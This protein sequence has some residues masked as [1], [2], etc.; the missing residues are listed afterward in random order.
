MTWMLLA[1]SA[2]TRDLPDG[3]EDAEVANGVVQSQCTGAS[4][5]E[6]RIAAMWVGDPPEV[7]LLVSSTPFRCEQRVA[8]LY[9][10]GADGLDVLLQPEFMALATD[11]GCFCTYDVEV[12]VVTP[13]DPYEQVTV[14]RRGDPLAGPYEPIVVGTVRLDGEPASRD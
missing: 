8:A 13:E 2:C 9:R 6:E 11:S 12:N 4:P 10:P 1:L 3:W 5:G 14:F 7:R